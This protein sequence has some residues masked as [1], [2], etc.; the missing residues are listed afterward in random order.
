[1]PLAARA[2]VMGLID[3]PPSVGLNEASTA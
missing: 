3:E 2:E 1:M